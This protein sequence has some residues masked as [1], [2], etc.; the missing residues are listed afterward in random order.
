METLFQDLRYGFR[1]LIKSPGFTAVAIV[2]FPESDRLVTVHENKPNFEDGSVSYPN[3][4]DWQKDNRTFSAVAVG[5]I[6]AFS[7][8]GIG[9]A[10]QVG[11]EFISSDFFPVLGVR[12]VIGRT[13]AQEEGQIGAGPVALISEGLWRRK[14]S[15]TPDILGTNVTLDARDYTIVG[16][17]PANFHLQVPGFRDTDVYAPVG[18]W[19]NPLLLKRGTGLGFHG[20]GRLKPGVTIEQARTDSRH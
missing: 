13:F 9:E 8:T 18:Q 2:T 7:L 1:M 20:I 16:V 12:P 10:E 14:F 19:S 4:R 3:F 17:I 6:Y 5:R 11:G 15:S